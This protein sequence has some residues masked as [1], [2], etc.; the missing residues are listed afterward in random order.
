MVAFNAKTL[1]DN[2]VAEPT[3]IADLWDMPADKISFLTEARDT[4]PMTMLK[5]G[6]DPDP[7]TITADDLQKVHDDIKPLVDTGLR[8]LDNA[9]IAEFASGSVWAAMVWSGDLASSGGEDDKIVFPEEG[10]M[11]WTDNMLIPKGAANK[12]NAE[13]LID[14]YYRPDVAAESAAYIYYVSP[15]EGVKE[16]IADIDDTA[17]DNPLLFPTADVV[18]KS[19]VFQF[20]SE[21]LE[22]KM[23]E[24]FLELTGA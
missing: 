13:A 5:L 4:F 23:D 6:I 19:H 3:K 2:N 8:F 15:V 11:L 22:K 20:L 21:D 14:Y 12:R 1:A 24:L 17:P 9:Y 10:V 7:A 18:A 16:A